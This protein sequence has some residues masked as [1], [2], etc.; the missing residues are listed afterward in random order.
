MLT[1]LQ[2]GERHWVRVPQGTMKP[3]AMQQF[4]EETGITAEVDLTTTK[5][6]FDFFSVFF[7]LEFVGSLVDRT[8]AYAE[9]RDA[10]AQPAQPS[11]PAQP[12]KPTQPVPAKRKSKPWHPTTPTE[13]VKF[14]SF[15][16]IMGLIRKPRINY[17]WMTAP[18]ICTPIFGRVITSDRFNIVLR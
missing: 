5:S 12:A 2:Q 7:T 16:F 9:R 18:E 15:I 4:Q 17:Y 8:N 1:T 3:N 14:L 13:M 6:A 10:N 11:Q